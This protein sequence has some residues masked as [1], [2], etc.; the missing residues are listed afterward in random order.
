MKKYI[1]YHFPSIR[2]HNLG[3]TESNYDFICLNFIILPWVT[4]LRESME[5]KAGYA[6]SEF[7]NK[8]YTSNNK[9]TYGLYLAIKACELIS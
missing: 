3:C 6:I 2:M 9:F 8:Q 1:F 5:V 7:K 4:N